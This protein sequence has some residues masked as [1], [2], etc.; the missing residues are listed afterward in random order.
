MNSPR[1][2]ICGLTRLDD[3][4]M[5]SSCGAWALGFIF[6]EKSP[7]YLSFEKAQKLFFSL[8]QT[9]KNA[10]PTM[11]GVFVDATAAII[12][13]HVETLGLEVIQLHGDETP[14]FC[15]SLKAQRSHIRV[16]KAF[17]FDAPSQLAAIE[18]YRVCDAILLDT[19]VPGQKG[20][21]GLVNDIEL[22]N[23]ALPM[24]EKIIFAGGL[25]PENIA[26]IS[27]NV[28]AYAFDVSSG[29]EVSPGVKD[30]KKMR[31]LFGNARNV[32]C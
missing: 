28:Q 10:A 31:L 27:A 26:S 18:S 4:L 24:H 21:T 11:V 23:A 1:I 25:R 19:Y 15:A 16:V 3:A 14:E 6:Y 2:K 20:G 17:R 5:A 8:R 22:V 29:I 7:R 9:L 12:L 32:S 30:E 13:D